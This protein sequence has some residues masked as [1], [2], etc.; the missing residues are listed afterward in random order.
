MWKCVFKKGNNRGS[1]FDREPLNDEFTQYMHPSQCAFFN[2]VPQRYIWNGD[3][4]VEWPGWADEQQ[5]QA[6]AAAVAEQEHEIRKK[7]A[8][9]LVSITQPYGDA[10]RETWKTQE[11]EANHW[12]ADHDTP[13]VMIRAMAT[14]RGITVD[15]MAAKILKNAELFRA[16]SGQILG[17]QQAE[18]DLL[19]PDKKE[20]V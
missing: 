4:I 5:E 1:G 18:L 10:E 11:E 20:E 14:T 7:Y 9:M 3:G 15:L 13:C 16:A 8:A 19:Y 17:M 6:Y 12:T 2:I